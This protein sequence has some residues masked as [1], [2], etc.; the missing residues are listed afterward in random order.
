MEKN[1]WTKKKKTIEEKQIERTIRRHTY[2]CSIPGN[3]FSK[4][5]AENHTK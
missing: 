4:L 3:F 5:T 1:A 2:V